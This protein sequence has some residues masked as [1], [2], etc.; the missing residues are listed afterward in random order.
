[1]V[2]SGEAVT[3]ERPASLITPNSLTGPAT[4]DPNLGANVAPNVLGQNITVG[5]GDPSV[6]ALGMPVKSYAQL[7]GAREPGQPGVVGMNLPGGGYFKGS[8]PK[9]YS[10]L[11]ATRP[12]FAGR[13]EAA[14]NVTPTEAGAYSG[15][16]AF[17]P[18]TTAFTTGGSAAQPEAQPTNL[19]P[20]GPI[21]QPAK[22]Q[23]GM[24]GQTPVD[25]ATVAYT[26]GIS[27]TAQDIAARA[28]NPVTTPYGPGSNQA[29]DAAAQAALAK[30]PPPIVPPPKKKIES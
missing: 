28:A 1:M 10:E 16:P 11:P 24:A 7:Y 23:I 13:A 5:A 14:R 30:L 15:A 2:A 18:P 22:I 29:L 27:N 12:S 4:Y 9:T 8:L 3:G 19:P 21:N 6:N 26:G 25:L 20:P 17:I